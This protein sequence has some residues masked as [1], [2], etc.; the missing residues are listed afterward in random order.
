MSGVNGNN[1]SDDQ[2]LPPL[3]EPVAELSADERALYSRHL[4]LGAIGEEGQRRLRAASVFV[5]GAGGLGSPVLLYLAAAGV[6]RI[7]VVDDDEVDLANLHRQVIH[8]GR[9][10]YSV[11]QHGSAFIK[12]LKCALSCLAICEDYMAEP[13][14]RF[15]PEHREK[16]QKHLADIGLVG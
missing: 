7:T 3:V 2:G 15:R 6:G 5:V 16:I 1:A 10:I 9:T 13:F 4:L 8:I 11:G 14:L 12:G